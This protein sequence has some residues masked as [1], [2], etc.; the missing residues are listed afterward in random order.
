MKKKGN[1]CD[2]KEE[3]NLQ[4]KK[5][6]RD[7]LRNPEVNDTKKIF[8]MVSK[9]SAP[10]FFISEQRA[11]NLLRSFRRT[12]SW[13]ANMVPSRRAMMEEIHHR[14]HKHLEDNPGEALSNAV[15]TI[16]N[17]PAPSFYLTPGSTKTILYNLLKNGSTKPN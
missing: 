4:L 13:P 3:R 5:A 8:E 6:F 2:Y 12:G 10:R 7:I 1:C 14:V 15:F 16:V 17:S 11:L 9:A